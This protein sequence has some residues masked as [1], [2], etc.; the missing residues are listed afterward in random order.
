MTG[1]CKV[2]IKS[3][4]APTEHIIDKKGKKQWYC[5][6]HKEKLNQ[7]LCDPKKKVESLQLEFKDGGFRDKIENINEKSIK[8]ANAVKAV[9]QKE[10]PAENQNLPVAA[11]TKP[12]LDKVY[13]NLMTIVSKGFEN[14]MF[15]AGQYLIETFYGGDY[16]IAKKD[17]KKQSLNSLNQYILKLR[18]NNP[19]APGKSWIYN[20]VNLVIEHE[21][22]KAHSDKLFHTYGMLPLSHKVLLFPVKEM[23]S[24]ERFIEYAAEHKPT[25]VE[26]REKIDGSKSSKSQKIESSPSLLKIIA[27]PERLFNDDL[28]KFLTPR[29]A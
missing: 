13:N 29:G 22:I 8:L 18:E 21:T 20:A 3:A 16:K 17:K 24:K 2:G 5:G 28:S 15:E 27:N 4:I 14:T 25:V 9:W 19:G 11:A 12:D 23:S 10:M 7:K 6:N 26:F 1:L